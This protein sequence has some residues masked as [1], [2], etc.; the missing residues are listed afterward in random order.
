MVAQS[1]AEVAGQADVIELFA[2][3]E[4]VHTVAVADVVADD[5]LVF[6]QGLASN[7]F[8][9]LA[10]EGR[11]FWHT[12][13]CKADG[14]ASSMVVTGGGCGEKECAAGARG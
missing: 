14:V 6:L 2:A 5:V 4:G 7:V 3:V 10:N 13:E 11:S 8:Q 1:G 9:M 12:G